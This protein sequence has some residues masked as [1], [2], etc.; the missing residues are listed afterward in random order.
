MDVCCVLSGRD[1]CE[2]LIPRPEEFY[3]L[4]CVIVCDL[5]TS[6]MRWPWPTLGCWARKKILSVCQAQQPNVGQGHLIL[7][8]S[9]S[10]TVTHHSR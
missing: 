9:R 6:S 2:G 8:V 4:W 7:E 10:H 5:Q 3:R 1:L